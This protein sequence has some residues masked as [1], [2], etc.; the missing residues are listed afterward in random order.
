M[1]LLFGLISAF[2]FASGSILFRVGQRDRPNDDGHLVGNFVNVVCFALAA[3][4]VRWPPWNLGGFVALV[5]GGIL[6]TV[7][8]RW[9]LLRGIRLIGP[10]RSSTFQTATPISAAIAGWIVLGEQVSPLEAAGAALTIFGLI[11]IIRGRTSGPVIESAPLSSYLITA[12]APAAFGIAFVLRKWGLERMPGAVT[13][14]LI[15]SAAGL[16]VLTAWDTGRG[17][18]GPLIRNTIASPPLP[19]LGAGV[20]TSAALLTQFRAL[21]LIEAWVVGI[22]NGTMA[23]WTILLSIAFLKNDERITAQLCLNIG[24]VFAGVVIVAVV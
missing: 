24:L 18:V 19:F 4:F 12:I 17:R 21:E 11:R 22:L 14:V 6:G 2:C 3:Q 7:I 13:G 5:V 8:G 10:S 23:I 20:I 9:S 1:G 15:G 16:L